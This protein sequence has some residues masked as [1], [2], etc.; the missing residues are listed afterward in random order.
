MKGFTII[1]TL[2][3]ISILMVILVAPFK[4]AELALTSSYAARDELI[5]NSLA[6]EAT[7]Y[8]HELRGNDYLINY[9]HSGTPTWL[10]GLD[11]T[12]STPNC[13]SPALCT[14][15][16]NP[17]AA[18]HIAQCYSGSGV[19]NCPSLPLYTTSAGLYTQVATSNTITRFYRTVQICYIGG[20]NCSTPTNEAKVTVNLTW[21]TSHQT[22]TTTITDYLT[23]W[24]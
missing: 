16:I 22:Y 11:G 2:V 13:I 20:A 15:D 12:A 6:Q 8:V 3:A 4:T 24:L 19:N 10:Q 7:E 14:L 17:N 18:T 1:E 9:Q 5:A 23:N 21:S